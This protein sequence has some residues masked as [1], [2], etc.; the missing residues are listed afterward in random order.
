MCQEQAQNIGGL[1]KEPENVPVIAM[2]WVT[3]QKLYLV[4][5]QPHTAQ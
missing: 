2:V 5:Q 4:N 1:H 3:M